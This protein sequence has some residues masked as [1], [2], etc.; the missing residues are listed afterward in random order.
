V[1]D[2]VLDQR[3]QD[4]MGHGDVVQ[5]LGNLDLDPQAIAK[6]RLLDADVERQVVE[7]LLDVTSSWPAASSRTR[8][9]SESRLIVRGLARRA[10]D[11]RP[12]RCA[13]S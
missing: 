1:L 13:A 6:P 4:E 2:G 12:P 3:L 5:G 9:N 10:L 7:L 11:Q 8:R